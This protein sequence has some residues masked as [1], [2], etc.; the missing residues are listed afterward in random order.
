[1]QIKAIIT[2]LDRTLLRTDKSISEYTVGVLEQCRK[3]G[4][5]ILAAS[6]RP[7]RDVAEFGKI[8]RFDAAIATNGAVVDLPGKRLEYGIDNNTAEKELERLLTYR[9][10]WLSVETDRG[11]FSDRDIPDW[12]PTVYG[13]FPKL[14][15]G[16]LL[17]KIIASSSEPSFY[18][19]AGNTL[20]RE[21]YSTV[22]DK[23]LIQIMSSDA[24][25]W[26]GVRQM[27]SHF[28]VDTENAVYFGDDNDDIEP[29]KNCGLGV[30]VANAIPAVISAADEIAL[31]NDEDGVAVFLERVLK[32]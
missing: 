13:G 27:L 16:V 21:T 22:A 6:A 20:T 24:T 14:P 19:T 15:E 2:D 11:L 25:K 4:I 30:A 5:L 7:I 17:Y 10:I 3:K 32:I 29:I 9:D 8:V 31:S 26:K 28:G 23:T 18:E 1:M 12:K